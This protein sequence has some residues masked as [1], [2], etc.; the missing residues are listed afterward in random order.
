MKVV[1]INRADIIGGRFNNY[2]LRDAWRE[3]GVQSS[4][5]VWEKA[6]EDPRVKL[7]FPFRGSRF[8][9]RALSKL[10]RELSMHSMLQLQSFALPLHRE[11]RE[12]DVAHYHII[13]DGYFSLLA[14]PMLSRMKPSVWTWHDPWPMTGHC[15]YPIQCQRWRS[16]CGSCPDLSLY[17]AMKQDRTA[18]AFTTKRNTIHNMDIDIVVASQFMHRMAR[19][20]PMGRGAR[21][22]LIPFGLDLDLYQK[23]DRAASRRR[24]GIDEDRVVIALRAISSPFKGLQHFI[25]AINALES[26]VPITILT[27]QETGYFNNLLGKHQI[28]ELGWVNDDDVIVDALS[29]SD[30]FAMP[31]T[32]EAF[33]LMAIEAMACGLPVVVFEGTS[34]PDVVFAPKAG[35]AVPMRNSA[36][37]A[38]ALRQLVE[39]PE[40]RRFRG[41]KSRQLAQQHY[42]LPLFVE[43]LSK[44]YKEVATRKTRAVHGA[45]RANSTAH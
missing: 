9:N 31:S 5:L 41:E 30:I 12:A 38:S 23:R 22:H 21:L 8:I 43:R 14:M 29:A 33:G 19:T 42:S 11:F 1:Q 44:L 37:L 10:E 40:E 32:A 24:F 20:S 7:L 39:N 13:H 27:F 6:G 2:N 15:V 25:E 3:H 45:V 4:H 26:Q 36:A 35:L 18:Q 28:I 17:F 34:L 16:G